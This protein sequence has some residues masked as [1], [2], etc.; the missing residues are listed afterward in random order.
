MTR[1]TLRIEIA[2]QPKPF[3]ARPVMRREVVDFTRV[4]DDAAL[5]TGRAQRVSLQLQR[6]ELTPAGREVAAL[7][8]VGSRVVAGFATVLARAGDQ[9]VTGAAAMEGR[10]HQSARGIAVS[11]HR[12][13]SPLQRSM[14]S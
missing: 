10:L 8:G 14:A 11:R 5:Q 4:F 2:P 12:A 3:V 1:M 9:A 7:K 6:P 13:Q